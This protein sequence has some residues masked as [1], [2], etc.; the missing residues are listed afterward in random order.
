MGCVSA[1]QIL[2]QAAEAA[3]LLTHPVD[4]VADAAGVLAAAVAWCMR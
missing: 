3:V 4:T 1:L 2:Q